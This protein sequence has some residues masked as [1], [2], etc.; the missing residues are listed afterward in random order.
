MILRLGRV[1]LDLP[2]HALDERVDAA[3]GDVGVV[4]PDAPHQRFAAEDDPLV[5][6][7]QVQ[8]LELVG[9]QIDFAL[10]EPRVAPRG[11]DDEV[12]PR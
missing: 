3:L 10:A 7:E 4:S 11:I 5:A 2:A 1:A 9:R 12:R 6:R 8:Q